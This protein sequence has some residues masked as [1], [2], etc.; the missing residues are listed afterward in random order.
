MSDVKPEFKGAV[1]A[2]PAPDL[3]LDF[4][5][6]WVSRLFEGDE[7][8]ASIGRLIVATRYLPG[9]EIRGDETKPDNLWPAV[10]VLSGREGLPATRPL[11][12]IAADLRNAVPTL[13]E[14]MPMAFDEVDV[15]Y[16]KS[17]DQLHPEAFIMLLP[18]VDHFLARLTSERQSVLTHVHTN[19][20]HI[21]KRTPKRQLDMT[22]AYAPPGTDP[23]V[24]E[25][26]KSIVAAEGQLRGVL[27][28]AT[29]PDGS[30]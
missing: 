1:T 23:E 11:P 30:E 2:E 7:V 21:G 15:M 18:T 3:E 13:Q 5:R 19:G 22:I 17:R 20:V 25:E 16:G 4:G 26:V 14:E 6:F 24:V 27:L 9:I 28:P 8:R 12:E 29:M 10:Q